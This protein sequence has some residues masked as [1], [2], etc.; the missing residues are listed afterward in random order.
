MTVCRFST[1]HQN[2]TM[3]QVK[4]MVYDSHNLTSML[5]RI[6]WF[7]HLKKSSEAIH[8]SCIWFPEQL[9]QKISSRLEDSDLQFVEMMFLMA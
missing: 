6:F 5:I 8:D 2:M 9:G 1:S 3:V 4:L 7:L